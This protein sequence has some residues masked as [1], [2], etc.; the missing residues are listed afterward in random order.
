MRRDSILFVT[1]GKNYLDESIRD[2]L[3]ENGFKVIQSRAEK[4]VL[5]KATERAVVAMFLF[6][7]DKILNASNK[8][9]AIKD[10]ALQEDI[11]IFLLGQKEDVIKAQTILPPHTV[12]ESYIRPIDIKEVA[13]KVRM[14]VDR[15][16]GEE[17]RNILVVDDSGAYLRSVREWLGDKYQ[18]TLAN[19]GTMA[20]KSMT[21]KKP[22]LILLDYEM[23]VV[24]G[25]QV[26]EMIRWEPE[27]S[28]IPVIF[29]TGKNDKQSIMNVMSL[30]PDGYLLKTMEPI[31]IIRAVDEFF[32]RQRF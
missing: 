22:D 7:E 25:K 13:I 3:S 17:R 28:E 4:E 29:L 31:E 6:V 21:L 14:T 19:S 16:S 1:E 27:F 24:D 11:P 15:F 26:L 23:P 9:E 20:I 2:N 30:K 32:S 10:C 18:V 5:E 12:T 8:L